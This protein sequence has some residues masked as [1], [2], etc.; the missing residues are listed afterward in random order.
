MPDTDEGPKYTGFVV[1]TLNVQLFHAAQILKPG[2]L[3]PT[4]KCTLVSQ[5][6]V[7]WLIPEE[8]AKREAFIDALRDLI[9]QYREHPE[10]FGG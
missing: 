7:A 2:C 8:N 9:E 10:R 4:P 3:V 5:V 1:K 6:F